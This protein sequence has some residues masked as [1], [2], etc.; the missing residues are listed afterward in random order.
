MT[1][2]CSNCHKEQN[3][4][5]WYIYDNIYHKDCTNCGLNLS[6]NKKEAKSALIANGTKVKLKKDGRTGIID[7]NDFENTDYSAHINVAGSKRHSIHLE[8]G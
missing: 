5:N 6:I 8:V 3:F 2:F 4:E 7:G 1:M